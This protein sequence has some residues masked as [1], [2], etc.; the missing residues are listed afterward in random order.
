MPPKESNSFVGFKSSLFPFSEA[1]WSQAARPFSP[2]P[3]TAEVHSAGQSRGPR[4]MGQRRQIVGRL[5][6]GEDPAAGLFWWCS[7]SAFGDAHNALADDSAKSGTVE[8][9]L[10]VCPS[11]EKTAAVRPFIKAPRESSDV[12]SPDYNCPCKMLVRRQESRD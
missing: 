8:L 12:E 6:A 4:S 7:L 11:G 1:D 3:A 10:N 2:K 9:Y 5:P